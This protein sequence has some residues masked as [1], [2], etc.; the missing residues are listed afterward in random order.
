MIQTQIKMT[1]LYKRLSEVGFPEKFVR[2]KALPD[3]WDEEFE[4]TPGAVVEAAAY[5]SRRL[6]LD[7]TS[8]LEPSATPVFKQSCQAKFKTKQGTT[9]QQLLVAYCMATRI[10]EMVAYAC[11]QKYNLLPAESKLVRD[12]ILKHQQ[13][14]NLEGLLKLCWNYG[15]PVVHFDGFPL[16][17]EVYKF[18][19]MVAFFEERPVIVI[20]LN[21]CS[22]TR[23]LFILAHVLGQIIKGHVNNYA[24]VYEEIEIENVDIEEI[25][26]KVFAVEILLGKP[27]VASSTNYNFKGEQLAAYA[28]KISERDDITKTINHYALQYLDLDRLDEDSQDYL[29]LALME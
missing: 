17:Q 4:T 15:I 11:V 7:I 22:P 2:D 13:L 3:W 19:A 27:D 18:N 1:T 12:E 26:A 29:K 9:N 20:S 28:Q 21:Q 6:N 16:A 8:L 23:L 14:V 25:E 10:A 24:I 5:V